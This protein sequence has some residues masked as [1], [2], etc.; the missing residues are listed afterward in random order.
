[1]YA[2][3][4][5]RISALAKV[6]LHLYGY[7]LGYRWC[8][9]KVTRTSAL[10]TDIHADVRADIRADSLTREIPTVKTPDGCFDPPPPSRL[11]T[12]NPP[13]KTEKA[14]EGVEIKRTVRERGR[15]GATCNPPPGTFA[16]NFASHFPRHPRRCLGWNVKRNRRRKEVRKQRSEIMVA[17]RYCTLEG[18]LT[19]NIH[20]TLGEHCKSMFAERSWSV[21][22]VFRSLEFEHSANI[23][24]CKCSN[25]CRIFSEEF[26]LLGTLF[27]TLKWSLFA[28]SMRWG[29]I[30]QTPSGKS[31]FR[32][33]LT[34][35]QRCQESDN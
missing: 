24:Y 27:L 35:R 7:P 4:S 34:L 19:T 8:T 25:I 20:E 16:R 18:I 31:V 32:E 14:M 5:A 28:W 21:R 9:D 15:V 26:V 29:G 2:R 1:M 6:V 33:S 22:R 10:W 17:A 12:Q 13:F 30:S 3:I 23:R 11:Q